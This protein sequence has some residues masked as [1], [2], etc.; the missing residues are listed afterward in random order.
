MVIVISL[1]VWAASVLGFSFEVRTWTEM[2]NGALKACT[3]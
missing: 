1:F 3:G 2:K